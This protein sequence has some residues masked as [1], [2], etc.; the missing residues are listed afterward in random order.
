MIVTVSVVKDVTVTIA[1]PDLFVS[2]VEVA[3]IVAVPALD[4]VKIPAPL[5]APMLVGLTDH[6]TVEL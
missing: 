6:V 4:G 1:K 5:I 3:V 2:S